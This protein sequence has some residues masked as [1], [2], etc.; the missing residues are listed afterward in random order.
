MIRTPWVFRPSSGS[1]CS[2]ASSAIT[3]EGAQS[4]QHRAQFITRLLL[5][6]TPPEGIEGAPVRRAPDSL[7]VPESNAAHLVPID[8]LPNVQLESLADTCT[9]AADGDKY[10]PAHPSA[11]TS[12]SVQCA[13]NCTHL[14][15]NG[16]TATAR[17]SSMR[18]TYSSRR[19]RSYGEL[20]HRREP[21]LRMHSSSLRPSLAPW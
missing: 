8:H 14:E 12:T 17:C 4:L 15:T 11:G 9:P 20:T 2:F 19:A 3:L 21:A 10:A 18:S 7:I 5:A 6:D 1:A 13:T 16:K